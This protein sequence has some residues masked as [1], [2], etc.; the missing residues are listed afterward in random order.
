MADYDVAVLGAGP[1][2]LTAALYAGR[3]RLKVA[4]IERGV[5]GGQAATTERIENYPGFPGGIGGMELAERMEKHARE[6]GAEFIPAEVTGLEAD[7]DRK[8]DFF[9]RHVGAGEGA[10][11]LTSRSVIVA[12]G[13]KEKTLGVPGEKEFRGRGVS[14]CATCDGAF[15]RGKVVAV[16]GGGDSAVE[17]ALYLT[18]YAE[19]VHVIHRRERLRANKILQERALRNDKIQFLWETVV[20]E[21]K[22]AEGGF[23]ERL[24]VKNVRSG[25]ENEVKA[26]G[27][28]IYVGQM[29]NTAF[30][31]GFLALDDEG[32]VV[33][34]E[35]L[36]T[37][38]KG[39]FA[40]GD[41]RRKKLRQVSTAVGDGALAAMSAARYLE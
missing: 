26:D 2:G 12:T 18:R 29:P 34:D 13:T 19:R 10:S 22:G 23:V 25:D 33:T 6:F 21:I 36:E 28:F 8:G 16:V 41:V 17:E 11:G 27:V 37:S 15:F 1:A 5:P 4:V 20:L 32:Y 30:L 35:D 24:R 14:Y 7:P 39:V 3:S 31:K 40:A 9:V 38:V